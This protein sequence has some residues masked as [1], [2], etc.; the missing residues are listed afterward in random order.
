[1]SYT[2]AECNPSK[3]TDEEVID[4]IEITGNNF[5]GS[6]RYTTPPKTAAEMILYAKLGRSLKIA[7]HGNKDTD[8][9]AYHDWL[10]E[11]RDFLKVLVAYVNSKAAGDKTAVIESGFKCSKDKTKGVSV[12][13]SAKPSNIPG[14]ID[15]YYK[16]KPG[17]TGVSHQVCTNPATEEGYMPQR[18]SESGTF[19][20]TG[21][22]SNTK[23]W[24]RSCYA[25]P[26]GQS[27]WS[28]PISVMVP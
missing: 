2:K 5:T 12:K 14:A 10:I 28:E 7:A 21:L 11:A 3:M 16:P 23:V 24:T 1:M 13:H 22:V 25:I 26:G 27:A 6:V 17:K 4:Q 20:W 8:V 18:M 19:T 15:I 9:A